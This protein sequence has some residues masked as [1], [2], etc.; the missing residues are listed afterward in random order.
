MGDVEKQTQGD[1]AHTEAGMGE[2]A[3]SPG[4]EGSSPGTS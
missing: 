1:A 3:T 2:V 4:V